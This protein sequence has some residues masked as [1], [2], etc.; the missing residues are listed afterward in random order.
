MMDEM[1]KMMKRLLKEQREDLVKELRTELRE[2]I[3]REVKLEV[4][5]EV[6]KNRL[7]EQDAKKKLEE[8][9]ERM[10]KKIKGLKKKK[11]EQERRERRFNVVIR[12][13][14]IEGGK[15]RDTVSGVLKRMEDLEKSIQIREVFKIRNGENEN[16][17]L[18]KLNNMD[19][20]RMI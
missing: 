9:I 16:I 19:D 7:E 15:V 4:K 1:E 8:E 3:R 6:E 14:E 17:I 11:M 12:G 13:I 20:K 18:V 2:E 10:R 5:K